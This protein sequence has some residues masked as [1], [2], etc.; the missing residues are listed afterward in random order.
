MLIKIDH[1]FYERLTPTEKQVITYINMNI[2]K[3]P[4][5]SILDLAEQTFSSPA[6]VSRTIKK[7]GIGGFAELRYL[8]SKKNAESKNSI[9]VNEILKKSLLEV[10]NTIDHLSIDSILKAVDLIK[11]APRIYILSRGLTELVAQ[12]FSLKLQLL[13]Y[14]IF[15]NSDAA[16][17]QAITNQIKRGELLIIFSLSGKTKEL[18]SSAENAVSLGAKMISCTCGDDTPLFQMATVALGGYKHQHVSIKSVDATSRFPLYVLSRIIIDYLT[19]QQN[20]EAK[21]V[22]K[23]AA[24]RTY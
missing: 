9:Q 1:T 12:E 21:K 6:T 5:M 22:Q 16:I 3:I 2:D 7:C 15:Q 11:N 8:L 17:M 18:V 13:G 20:P 4:N 23:K 24:G 14:N 19:L 10:S